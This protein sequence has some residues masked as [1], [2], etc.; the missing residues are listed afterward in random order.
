MIVQ[1]WSD[2]AYQGLP[3]ASENLGAQ[4]NEPPFSSPPD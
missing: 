3:L 1:V 4:F 2:L